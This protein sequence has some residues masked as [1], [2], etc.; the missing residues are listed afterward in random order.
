ML[1]GSTP[2]LS[3]DSKC[4]G[5]Q[6]GKAANFKR[7]CLRVRLPPAV[8]RFR[9][10]QVVEP[11]DTRH[12]ECRAHRGVRVQLSPWLLF[13]K[14]LQVRQVSNWLSY[15]RYARLDTETCNLT[16]MGQCS[17]EFHTLRPPGATPG[18]ATCETTRYANRQSGHVED[19][20]ILWVRFPLWSL[21]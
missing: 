2:A 8:L 14:T 10:S 20:A 15:G 4:C 17:V 6:T 18:S 3:T 11:V 16:R 9:Y 5:T 19:V 21:K 13:Q 7:S 1:A 12:S